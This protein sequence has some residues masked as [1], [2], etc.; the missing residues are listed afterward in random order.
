MYID[1]KTK[2]LYREKV[3]QLRIKLSLTIHLSF[4]V[5]LN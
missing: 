5:V 3:N 4:Y 1:I 2:V